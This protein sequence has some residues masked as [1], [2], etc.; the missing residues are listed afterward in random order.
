MVEAYNIS[1]IIDVIMRRR[2][3]SCGLRWRAA[4][5]LMMCQDG[6]CESVAWLTVLGAYTVCAWTVD[7]HSVLAEVSA[8]GKPA[9]LVLCGSRGS[10]CIGRA[11]AVCVLSSP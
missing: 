5:A 4:V 11:R 10:A 6:A 9:R 3:T 2:M 8:M 1:W 7:A